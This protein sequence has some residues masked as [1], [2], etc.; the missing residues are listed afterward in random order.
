MEGN[1]LSANEVLYF[2][3]CFFCTDHNVF[4]LIYS[5]LEFELVAFGF[6]VDFGRLKSPYQEVGRIK[7]K[8]KCFIFNAV[9][10][11]DIY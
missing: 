3:I 7:N 11:K 10:K 1:F 4:L 2:N 8:F 6:K 9:K 5:D